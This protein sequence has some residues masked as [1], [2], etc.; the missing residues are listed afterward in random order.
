MCLRSLSVLYLCSQL[1]KCNSSDKRK[2]LLKISAA[3][4][5]IS[6]QPVVVLLQAVCSKTPNEIFK[7]PLEGDATTL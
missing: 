5:F 2:G 4:N 6:K 3:S 7:L 1:P